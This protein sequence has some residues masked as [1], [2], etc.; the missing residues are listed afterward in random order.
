MHLNRLISKENIGQHSQ[1][2]YGFI[3][4]RISCRFPNIAVHVVQA[5]R[6]GQFLFYSSLTGVVC[7][8]L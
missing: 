6:V 3:P 4:M 1:T 5:K 7:V 8:M 2:R